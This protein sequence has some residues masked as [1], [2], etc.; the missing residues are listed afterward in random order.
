MEVHAASVVC[1]R[2]GTVSH[3]LHQNHWHL[4]RDLPISHY[5]QN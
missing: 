2:C 3:H 1:P 5:G 4:V